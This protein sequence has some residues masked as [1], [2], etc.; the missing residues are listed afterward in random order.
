MENIQRR[1]HANTLALSR[2][3]NS[4]KR[5]PSKLLLQVQHLLVK[6]KP[7]GWRR[8][9]L[10]TQCQNHVILSHMA[11]TFSCLLTNAQTNTFHLQDTREN[12]NTKTC[13]HFSRAVGVNDRLLWQPPHPTNMAG[14]RKHCRENRRGRVWK[15]T[16]RQF[17]AEDDNKWERCHSAEEMCSLGQVCQGWN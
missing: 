8:H 3:S 1:M 14:R 17:S 7:E 9:S 10:M 13:S 12:Y 5:N 2:W 16:W 15:L 6:M 4:R 11:E